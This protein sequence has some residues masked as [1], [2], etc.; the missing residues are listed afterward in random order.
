MHRMQGKQLLSKSLWGLESRY[1]PL[2]SF[3]AVTALPFYCWLSYG[4]N[5]LDIHEHRIGDGAFLSKQKGLKAP[6]SNLLVKAF[7]QSLGT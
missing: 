7:L 3:T 2:L 6:L 1:A 5:S 4:P